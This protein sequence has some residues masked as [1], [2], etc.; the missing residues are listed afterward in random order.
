MSLQEFICLCPRFSVQHHDKLVEYRQESLLC[1]IISEVMQGSDQQQRLH[2][3]EEA[4]PS[5]LRLHSLFY[6]PQDLHVGAL[7]IEVEAFKQARPV[8]VFEYLQRAGKIEEVAPFFSL[9]Q[10]AQLCHQHLFRC[11]RH[12][13]G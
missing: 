9:Q 7:Q 2:V 13:L 8:Q 4:R 6:S 12:D 11:K 10:Y 3:I 5:P 1:R